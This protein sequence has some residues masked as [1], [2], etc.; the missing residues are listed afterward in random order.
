MKKS[1]SKKLLSLFLAVMMLATSLP[2]AAVTAVA[3]DLN[4]VT[5]CVTIDPVIYLHGAYNNDYDSEYAFMM[6]GDHIADGTKTGEY[7]TTFT[8]K[9]KTVKA[10]YA[11]E[12]DAS[13]GYTNN[14]LSGALGGSYG[15]VKTDTTGKSVTLRFEFT[16]NTYEKHTLAVKANPVPAHAIGWA[17]SAN[18]T[19][20]A[21][22]NGGNFRSPGFEVLAYNSYGYDTT[23]EEKYTDDTE[24]KKH[25]YRKDVNFPVLFNPYNSNYAMDAAGNVSS[26]NSWG[27]LNGATGNSLDS[28]NMK[29][30]GRT[31]GVQGWWATALAWDKNKKRDIT[32]N[33][34]H[35]VYYVDTSIKSVNS[36][37][38]YNNSQYELGFLVG[39][40]FTNF[41]A[42]GS[43]KTLETT[44]SYNNQPLSINRV[45]STNNGATD[46]KKEDING[47]TDIWGVNKNAQGNIIYQIGTPAAGDTNGTFTAI[48]RHGGSGDKSS[49]VTI[50]MPYTIHA[51]DKSALR[52]V[53]NNCVSEI[54]RSACY[55]DG[56]W[57][58][59]VAALREA[60]LYLNDYQADT[61]TEAGLKSNLETAFA[62]LSHTRN[63]RIDKETIKEISCFEDGSHYDITRCNV[64]GAEVAARVTV[65]DKA[66]G[67]HTYFCPDKNTPSVWTC[68][69]DASHTR[70]AELQNYNTVD[71]IYSS[72]DWDKYPADLAAVLKAVYTDYAAALDQ[73]VKD[74]IKDNPKNPV[75]DYIDGQV[76]DLLNAI[77]TYTTEDD[78]KVTYKVTFNVVLDGVASTVFVDDAVRY[79][80]LKEI[81][82][83]AEYLTEGATTS[84]TVTYDKDGTTKAVPANTTSYPLLVQQDTTVTAYITTEAKM[85]T[86]LNQYGNVMYSF[87]IPADGLDVTI[88]GN[89][90][91]IGGKTYNVPNMPYM[92]VKGFTFNGEEKTGT[93]TVTETT[94][95]RPVFENSSNATYDI[96]LDGNSVKSN[97]KYDTKITVTTDVADAKGLAVLEDG[98]YVVASYSNEY[99]FYA[100]HSMNFYTITKNENGKFV[101]NG[102]EFT[103]PMDVF[104][105]QNGLPFVYS[106]G[107]ITPEGKFMTVSAFTKDIPDGVTVVEAGTLYSRKNL[108]ADN[109]KLNTGNADIYQLASKT[110]TDFSN[111][112]MLIMSDKAVAKGT[113][114]TRAYVKYTYNYGDNEVTAIAYG[115]ICSSATQASN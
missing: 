91:I 43:G 15:E 71:M 96:T 61:S 113:I 50:N 83:P 41:N 18:G 51:V 60:E 32:L 40:I 107:A 17:V 38:P 30:S 97:V 58:D 76:T 1:I 94:A 88:E 92:E 24:F 36:G 26:D 8:A 2:F 28:T 47:S 53:Y 49:R 70:S 115:N 64:C 21:W 69:N 27:S 108:N 111:Q 80:T 56:T 23:T 74:D 101:A 19:A 85:L 63:I 65:T 104:S 105:L 87:P 72:I 42:D 81:T 48:E 73:E 5:G 110:Q 95:I 90:L 93:V 3:A 13:L 45:E 37:L 4:E 7:K 84:W 35:A 79:G 14:T 46:I 86:I 82:I 75:Q 54:K 114:Y 67:Y 62:N 44:M 59:Y 98:K 102:V 11:E 10:V 9:G 34:P 106:A 22:R 89:N 109:F 52:T 29:I 99:S 16:D 20:V 78:Q 100:N 112:Y 12:T 25:D 31:Y 39:S 68:K 6:N 77:N 33:L 103:D 57:N 55:T 66:I